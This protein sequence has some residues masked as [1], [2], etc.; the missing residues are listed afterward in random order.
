MTRAPFENPDVRLD[1]RP[2]SEYTTFRLGASCRG[3][4]HCRMPAQVEE[5]IRS[6]VKEKKKFIL[7]GGGSN[8]VVSDEPLDCYVVRY[9]T[10]KPLIAL[11]GTDVTVSGSTLLDDLAIFAARNGLEGIEYATGIPG[12]VGGAVVGNAGAWGKQIADVLTSGE[13]I[14]PSGVK[15]T[16]GAEKL[17][18]AYRDSLLKKTGDMVVSVEL[19]L[20]KGEQRA[21]LQER[22]RILAERKAKHPDLRREPCAGSFF[23]N[24]EPT[25]KA[26]KRQAAGWFLEE[27]GGKTLKVGGAVIYPKHANIIVKSGGCRSQDVYELSLQ[28][29]RIVKEKFNLDLVREVRFVGKFRGMP[30]DVRDIIW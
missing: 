28:M 27:A 22:E 12:T 15:K 10:D 17:G 5:T 25:S 3:I 6:L 16:A 26:G 23:R 7:I 13:L 29:A 4:I 21:L 14:S 2:L 18:F 1:N 19:S 20:Q 9:Y 24:I 8:L 11:N 30:A